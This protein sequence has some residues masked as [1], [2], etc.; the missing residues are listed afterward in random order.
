VA[1]NVMPILISDQAPARNRQHAGELFSMSNVGFI[2][3]HAEAAPVAG[4][5]IPIGETGHSASQAT[6]GV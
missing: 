4:R 2:P 1:E 3:D 5:N 6:S